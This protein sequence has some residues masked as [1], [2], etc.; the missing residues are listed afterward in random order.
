VDRWGDCDATAG[1]VGREAEKK[2]KTGRGILD[3]LGLRA[4]TI[5]DLVGVESTALPPLGL[6][7]LVFS[8]AGEKARRISVDP[9]ERASIKL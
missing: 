9:A 7:A 4:F 5:R 6:V 1:E 2:L 3:S 8:G